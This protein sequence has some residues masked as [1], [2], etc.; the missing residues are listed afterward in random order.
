MPAGKR[1]EA[2]QADMADLIA[3]LFGPRILPFDR[4][5][6]AEHARLCAGARAAGRAIGLADG[7]IAAVALVPGF[8]VATRDASPFQAVGVSVIDPW[9]AS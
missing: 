2:L 7:Q 6:A 1:R 9:R 3:D 5:A 4:V 8:T